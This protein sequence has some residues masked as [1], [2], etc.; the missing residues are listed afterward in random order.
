MRRPI[1][2]LLISS[3]FFTIF[4]C[5]DSEPTDPVATV[6]FVH[7][8]DDIG[9]VEVLLDTDLFELCRDLVRQLGRDRNRTRE[10]QNHHEE[11]TEV[12][13]HSH[14]SGWHHLT[15]LGTQNAQQDH[16]IPCET[17]AWRPRP[18][19]R[20]GEFVRPVEIASETRG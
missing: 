1:Y 15:P 14:C 18:I 5:T 4:A 10:H 12:L 7:S 9:G 16:S 20:N 13:S 11:Q 19:L 17:R 3:L 2:F 6:R 8:V